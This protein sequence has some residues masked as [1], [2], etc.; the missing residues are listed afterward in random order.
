ML[1]VQVL[2]SNYGPVKEVS[3]S[4]KI[5]QV[6]QHVAVTT[7]N[8]SRGCKHTHTL[9]SVI[10]LTQ[11]KP[12]QNESG[13]HPDRQLWGIIHLISPTEKTHVKQHTVQLVC[14]GEESVP[15]YTYCTQKS[16]IVCR[17]S[18]YVR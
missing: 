2:R 17:R 13:C 7:L 6:I 11:G 4:N 18:G 15:H 12:C 16:K 1:Q 5:Q 14:L 3:L 8:S 9:L 10:L